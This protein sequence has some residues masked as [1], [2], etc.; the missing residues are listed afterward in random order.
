MDE[1]AKELGACGWTIPMHCTPREMS[2]MLDRA[3]AEPI[4][5]VF[6]KHYTEDGGKRGGLKEDLL[7][8]E[9]LEYWRPLLE[10]CLRA[11]EAGLYLVA[12]PALLT[13]IE[14]V[15]IRL[16]NNPKTTDPRTVARAALSRT[17]PDS[18]E[19]P[20]WAS[21][22]VFLS[23]LFANSSFS[24]TPP[25]TINRHWILHGRDRPV[26]DQA[27]CLRLLQALYTVVR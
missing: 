14:G 12:V 22:D 11:Y 10:Q 5:S 20:I 21:I 23:N 2:D 25:G 24:G 16:G 1:E 13:M 26:W 18:I 7:G 17:H 9:T 19:L 27:D 6:L 15:T 8:I 4:D 3:H